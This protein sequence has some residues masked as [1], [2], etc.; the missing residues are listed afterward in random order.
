[1]PAP[2]ASSVLQVLVVLDM[3]V[4]T[5]GIQAALL[6]LPGIEVTS[7]PL[8]GASGEEGERSGRPSLLVV[9]PPRDCAAACAP[10]APWRRIEP[11]P[12]VLCLAPA[13]CRR[14]CALADLSVPLTQMDLSE[15]RRLLREVLEQIRE[16]AQEGEREARSG[17]AWAMGVSAPASFHL[18]P[19]EREIGLLVA[20]GRSSAE[21][22]QAL[23]ISRRTVEKHRANLMAKLG[24]TSATA[25]T[26][27][28]L[29]LCWLRGWDRVRLAA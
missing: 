1:M 22:A 15:L 2:P 18:S 4:A 26:R 7:G 14:R 5:W 25:L 16:I 12:F 20:E 6:G 28:L 11:L 21:I 9:V 23:F 24:V 27:E 8:C 19:R 13:D 10:A 17:W 29:Y 3:P